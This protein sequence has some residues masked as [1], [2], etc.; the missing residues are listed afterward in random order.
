M[1]S[2]QSGTLQSRKVSQIPKISGPL[3]A[4]QAERSSSSFGTRC[5]IFKLQ[6]CNPFYLKVKSTFLRSVSGEGQD[7][8]RPCRVTKLLLLSIVSQFVSTVMYTV[9]HPTFI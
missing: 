2:W 3:S 8:S 5:L 7:V 4:A 6:K 1:L 9:L